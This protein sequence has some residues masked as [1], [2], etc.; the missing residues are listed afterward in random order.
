MELTKTQIV[1]KSLKTKK[2]NPENFWGWLFVS[3]PVIGTI[4]FV[5]IPFL[6]TIY[7]SFMS[8]SAM[9]PL[10]DAHFIG[11]KN[12]IK[13]IN[14]KHIWETLYNTVFYM[15]GIPIGMVL[16][17]LLAICMN[18]EI[19]FSSGF[20]VIFYIPVV[21]SIVSITLLFARLFDIEGVVNNILESL[22]IFKVFGIDRISW[23]EGPAWLKK[24]TIIIMM[25]WKGLGG[26]I[27]LFIAGL[28]GIN[29][30]YYEAA[31]LDGANSTRIFFTITLPQLY[32]VIF[33]V[34]VTSIIGG[35]QIFTEPALFYPRA[36]YEVM[37]LV[38]YLYNQQSLF[39]AG[40]T[41][42]IGI[43]LAVMVFIVT[44]IQFYIN[45]KRSNA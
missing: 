32:P 3:L 45:K 30:N 12:Y 9:V 23:V 31:K 24:F 7:A 5:F 14:D 20:R 39:K 17:L 15:I 40:Y 8:W 43:M 1:K 6:M 21:A 4:S 11:L 18:R 13:I 37:P 42:A 28:Q 2:K 16:S 25:V 19:K 41:A 26:T 44:A 29:K 33:F 22:G 27:L 10:F 38:L 34:L 36:G 35:A